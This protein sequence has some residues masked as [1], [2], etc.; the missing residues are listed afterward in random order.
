MRA[1]FENAKAIYLA[2]R[3]KNDQVFNV[4]FMRPCAAGV[5]SV[6]ESTSITPNQ[7]TLLGLGIF[8][9]AALV[10]VGLP[11]Y[12]G[13]V[14]GVLVIEVSYLFD[15]VDGM[16]ARHKKLASKEGHLF[17][18]F[19]DELKAT[20]LVGALALR[21]HRGGGYGPDFQYREA[22]TSTLFLVAGIVAVG[23]IASAISLT[24]FVRRPEISGRETS[25][26]A[27][28]ETVGTGPSSRTPVQWAAWAAT[29]FLRFLN[30]YPSHLWFVALIGR[31]DLFFWVYAL[32]NLAYLG[33][34]W[35]GLLVRFGGT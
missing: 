27:H 29:T 1:M 22:G 10:L 31:L 28:Y 13:G 34:G 18:F 6:L 33:R 5:V 2:T 26:E 14:L 23:V 17:D 11:S 9:L 3:K 20:L 12:G 24:N 19:T 25:V 16:L 7:V 4:Y 15:C 21:L 35:L 30:H 8:I 32:I